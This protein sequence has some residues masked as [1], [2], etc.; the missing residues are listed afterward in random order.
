MALVTPV[1]RLLARKSKS[2]R[3]TNLDVSQ[4][5]FSAAGAAIVAKAIKVNKTLTSLDLWC[6]RISD[7]SA[8]SLADAIQVNKTLT[9]VNF[10]ND[11]IGNAGAES[12][13]VQ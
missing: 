6:N 11:G 9:K 5:G 3:L 1:L 8:I 12:V 13:A 4:C 2:L 10:A 7:D